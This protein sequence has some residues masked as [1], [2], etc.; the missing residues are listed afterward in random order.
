[1]TALLLALLLQNTDKTQKQAPAKIAAEA[2]KGL[3]LA[4]HYTHGS[5]YKGKRFDGKISGYVR[6]DV[7]LPI[8]EP[9]IYAKG[10]NVLV[11]T[12]NGKYVPPNQVDQQSVEG[13]AIGAFR[14]PDTMLGE[15]ETASQ[16]IAPERRPDEKAG[17]VEC[18]LLVITLPNDLKKSAIKSMAGSFTGPIPMPNPDQFIDY[19]KTLCRYLVWVAK[20]D[21]AIVQ[22][23]F[24]LE[25]AAKKGGMPMGLP[26]GF[27]PASWTMEIMVEISTKDASPKPV[28]K[29]V[30][31]KLGIK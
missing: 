23:K 22:Y 13:K 26:G 30:Q 3:R 5:A 1:M 4:P 31:N 14:N 16:Q 8:D 20:S 24:E 2:V 19:D 12:K 6:K 29:E 27:D 7:H 21:L 9:E 11:K 15:I 18:A 10:S 25:V 17:D 28:P